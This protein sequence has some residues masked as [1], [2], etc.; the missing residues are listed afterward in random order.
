MTYKAWAKPDQQWKARRGRVARARSMTR[1]SILR[2]FPLDLYGFENH[3]DR[4][5]WFNRIA[6][7]L[8]MLFGIFLLIALIGGV[9]QSR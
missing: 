7:T 4:F 5:V 9:M 6:Y 2:I 8:F 1:N 3:R